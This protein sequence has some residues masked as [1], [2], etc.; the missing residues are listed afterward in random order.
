MLRRNYQQGLRKHATAAHAT[1]HLVKLTNTK[2]MRIHDDNRIRVRNIQARFDNARTYENIELA[3]NKGFHRVFKV[4]V[5]HLPVGNAHMCFRNK[6]LDIMSQLVNILNAVIHDKHLTA[7]G[8]F[9]FNRLL[10]D[11]VIA[12]H[13]LGFDRQAI[14]GRRVNQRNVADTRHAQME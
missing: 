9:V 12:L 14:H 11:H 3:G 13:E 2:V 6:F 8:E 5:I 1:T 4:T 7:T 10:D